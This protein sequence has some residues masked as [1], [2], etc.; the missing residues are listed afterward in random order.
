MKDSL[1][2]TVSKKDDGTWHGVL[3]L[4]RDNKLYGNAIVTDPKIGDGKADYPIIDILSELIVENFLD[5]L[6]KLRDRPTREEDE[7]RM[8]GAVKML[9]D[10]VQSR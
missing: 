7:Q 6:M 5:S 10:M 8:L 2:I 1:T 3:K 9:V 4:Q